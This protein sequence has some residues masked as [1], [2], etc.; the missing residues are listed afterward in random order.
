MKTHRKFPLLWLFVILLVVSMAC[1]IGGYSIAKDD[2]TQAPAAVTIQVITSPP[3]E[4]PADTALPPTETPQLPTET[5]TETATATLEPPTITPTIAH[6]VVPPESVPAGFKVYDVV[7]KDTAS[8]K[9]APYGDAYQIN[10]LERPFKQ[11][12]TYIEDL[13]LGS[14]SFSQD[15]SW[16]FVSIQS[17]GSNPNNEI[18]IQ[19]GVEL[20]TNAD[21]YGDYLLLAK[22]P[23]VPAWT[24]NVQIY[25][26]KNHDTSAKS[27]EK[28]DAPV[29]TDGYETLVFDGAAG[30][31]ED[32]D[33]AWVR[34][35]AGL[36]ATV[37]FA[38][39]KAFPSKW[40]MM[41]VFADA[42]IKDNAKL[43]YVDRF[44]E[45]DAGS[46][47]R[48]NKNYPLKELFL[49]DNICREAIGFEAT[50]YEPQ[51]C[52]R[53]EP[54]PGV[55]PAPGTT[56]VPWFPNFEFFC[57]KPSYCVGQGY[58]WDQ[59]ACRCNVVIY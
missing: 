32:V 21:G 58:A 6:V 5:P 45:A 3:T 18:G 44:T 2:P 8:E 46:P 4:A 51:L 10:R 29:T 53:E 48:S 50:G 42:G 41:G 56:L 52:P 34:V 23:F 25:Q 57:I 33:L 35:N 24:T 49:V 28:S 19:Y 20:D 1:Q 22:P 12:M 26:D 36:D 11:D 27:A 59:K 43:D 9:R 30:V 15:K 16:T 39:K 37:Q 17:V 7:S 14:Y 40:Y 13:D 54:T 47:V 31:G 38:F 55:T